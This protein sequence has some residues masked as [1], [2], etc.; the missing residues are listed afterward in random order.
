M[1][2]TCGD[3]PIVLKPGK[4]T[5]KDAGMTECNIGFCFDSGDFVALT[6]TPEDWGCVGD[7]DPWQK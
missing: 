2:R 3:C 1:A 5:L 4:Q 6:D 7:D